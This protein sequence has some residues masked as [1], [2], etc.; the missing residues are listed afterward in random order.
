MRSTI[1]AIKLLDGIM[2]LTMSVQS[3]DQ[4]VLQNI[5]RDNISLEHMM[6]LAPAIKETGLLTKAEVILGLPGETYQSTLETIRKLVRSEMDDITM[7][8]ILW[9][10][11]EY[12]RRT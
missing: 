8:S 10:R 11:N 5:K 9:C 6:A 1:D 7:C 4:A 3:M 2:S 12:A